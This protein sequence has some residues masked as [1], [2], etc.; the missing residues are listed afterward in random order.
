MNYFSHYLLIPDQQNEYSTLGCILPDLLRDKKID[1][2]YYLSNDFS[3]KNV[4]HQS[5]SFG[6]KNHIESDALFHNSTFFKSKTK[7]LARAIRNSDKISLSKYTYFV[8]HILLELY[9]DH[10]LVQDYPNI[11]D[12]FY[13]Q[14]DQTND[15]V[16]ENYF[17]KFLPYNDFEL[18]L[19][20]KDKFVSSKFLTNYSQLKNIGSFLSYVLEKVSIEKLSADEQ[21]ALVDLID[22]KF[23]VKIVEEIPLLLETMKKHL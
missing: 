8:A 3:H 6:I 23:G 12:Q 16:L 21:I 2:S 10:L 11:L 19:L 5:L 20:K 18:F 1:S 14:L 17:Q 13:V 9:I 7:Q 22:S 15:T 4:Q